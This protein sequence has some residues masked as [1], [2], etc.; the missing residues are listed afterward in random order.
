MNKM[1]YLGYKILLE[2]FSKHKKLSNS[3]E[4]I[5]ERWFAVYVGQSQQH[6]SVQVLKTTISTAG[7]MSKLQNAEKDVYALKSFML[8]CLPKL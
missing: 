8:S 5:P 6:I 1:K 2:S 7:I 3:L 4:S